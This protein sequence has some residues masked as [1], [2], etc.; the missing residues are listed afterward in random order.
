[1]RAGLESGL[2]TSSSQHKAAS[3]G[4]ST[5]TWLHLWPIVRPAHLCYRVTM[6]YPFHFGYDGIYQ[7][8]DNKPDAINMISPP[9]HREVHFHLILE[10]EIPFIIKESWANMHELT[11]MK[12]DTDLYLVF[13]GESHPVDYQR[14]WKKQEKVEDPWCIP[15]YPILKSSQLRYE[16][17][18]FSR[19]QNQSAQRA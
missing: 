3:E 17:V 16:K 2:F 6:E 13:K 7:H 18:A 4:R 9:K 8:P 12:R 11:H 15:I 19:P 10:L 1:M 5:K 14:R